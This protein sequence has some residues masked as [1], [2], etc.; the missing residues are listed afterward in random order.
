MGREW[1]IVEDEDKNPE[2]GYK[3]FGQSIIWGWRWTIYQSEDKYI[4]LIE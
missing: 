1:L 3:I 4:E 2:K